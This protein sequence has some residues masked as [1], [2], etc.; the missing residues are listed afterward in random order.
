MKIPSVSKSAPSSATTRARVRAAACVARARSRPSSTAASASRAR[1]ALDH[2]KLLNSWSTTRSFYSSIINDQG[3][4]RDP[5]AIVK[6]VQMHPA[7]NAVLHVDLQRVLET[8]RSACTA[9]PLHGTRRAAP[10]VKTQG[11]VVSH[12]RRRR[13]H[14]PAEGP[15]GVPRGR[16][17]GNDAER[18]AS[19]PTSAAGGRRRSELAQGR[20]VAV[21]SI[22]SPRAREPERR[23]PKRGGR[24]QRRCCRCEGGAAKKGDAKKDGGL[25]PEDAPEGGK[26]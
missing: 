3:R 20:D 24:G 4:R 19:C 6:D 23:R 17:L 15:A 13:G 16:H 10:G 25:P 9:D 22:H 11:G 21:V 1:M 8:R 26:K 2:Q 5:A 18:H 7:K 14:L 12:H